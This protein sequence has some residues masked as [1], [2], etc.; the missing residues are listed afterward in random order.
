MIG[1]TEG[2]DGGCSAGAGAGVAVATAC[3]SGLAPSGIGT[4]SQISSPATSREA[5]DTGGD[6]RGE[7]VGVRWGVVGAC[8]GAVDV[9]APVEPGVLEPAPLVPAEPDPDEPLPLPEPPAGVVLVW[10]VLVCDVVP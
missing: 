5:P 7:W 9:A 8:V 1:S 10:V 3:T 4:T 2:R 6:G